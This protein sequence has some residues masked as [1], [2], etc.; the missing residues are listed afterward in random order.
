[1]AGIAAP[2]REAAG[3]PPGGKLDRGEA[4]SPVRRLPDPYQ[5]CTQGR[6]SL[7]ELIGWKWQSCWRGV[8]S[9]VTLRFKVER[10]SD[11]MGHPPEPR[12][13]T[14]GEGSAEPSTDF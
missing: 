2:A 4:S 10:E 9:I 5:K 14:R 8:D 3:P 13:A 12:V 1:M 11:R 7:S 6:R